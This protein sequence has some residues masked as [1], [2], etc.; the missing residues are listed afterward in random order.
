MNTRAGHYVTQIEGYRS[1]VPEKLPPAN[2]PISFDME[3]IGLLSKADLALGRLDGITRTL[4]NP[5]LF[6]SMYVK[7]EALLSSQIEG[8][9]ASLIEVLETE[10]KQTSDALEVT[11]Y[12]NALNYGLSRLKDDGF[13]LSLRLI[14]EIHAKLLAT[15]R[16]SNLT[17]G[18]FRT[19][20][21]WIG[22]IGSTL[23]N[24][25]YIPPTASDMRDAM[26]DLE[27]YFHTDDGMPP[28]VKIALIHAQFET[29]HPF[30]DGN[31]RMGRL[32][33]TFWLCQQDILSYPLLYLSYFFKRNRSEYYDRL[34]AVRL[35]GKWEDWIKFFLRG[36]IEISN[37]SSES[38]HHIDSLREELAERINSLDAHTA[39]NARRLLDQLFITP[40]VTRASVAAEL[41]ITTPTAGA[42]IRRF[43]D[44]AILTDVAPDVKRGKRYSF[45]R[46]LKILE[47]GT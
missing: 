40:Q 15:G 30:L 46:Y 28:L 38:A 2:P 47:V 17:P 3:L 44:L 26:G 22:G 19:S 1:F 18:E 34:M 6:V 12:V 16:G 45:D 27:I 25:A 39:V 32:L 4:P 41:D 29:I 8:T 33:I 9:Q 11:N 13:P 7:K 43:C 21:N 14:R 35:Q 36:I 10:E 24:A 20:Q 31:G 37:E 42:L 23:T 5:D